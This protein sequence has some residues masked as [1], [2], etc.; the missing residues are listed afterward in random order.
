ME[1]DE[2]GEDVLVTLDDDEEFDNVADLFDDRFS[3]E[4]DYDEKQ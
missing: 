1:K 3:E 2:D 4:V